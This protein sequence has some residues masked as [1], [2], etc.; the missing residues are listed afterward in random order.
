MKLNMGCG[1][2]VLPDYTNVDIQI[3]PHNPTT[4]GDPDIICDLRSVPLPDGCASEVMAIHVFEHF[5]LW[6]AP[7]VLTEW[8]RLLR[9]EG[10]LV[11]EMP[12]LIKC[13]T[14]IINGIGLV[15]TGGKNP[16]ALGMW[17]L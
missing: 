8:H 3:W 16:H 2:R 13:C 9:P 17:G 10:K 1:Q 4:C 11:L 5:F 6:E 14:N 7:A 12:D 15:D